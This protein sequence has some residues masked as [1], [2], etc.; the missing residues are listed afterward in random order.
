M[1]L[2]GLGEEAEEGVGEGGVRAGLGG[3]RT[4]RDLQPKIRHEVLARHA[5]RQRHNRSRHARA[6]RKAQHADERSLPLHE[7]HHVM[8]RVPILGHFIIFEIAGAPR[9]RIV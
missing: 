1:G 7:A 8:D 3:G 2:D 6:D 4:Y 5:L 9:P